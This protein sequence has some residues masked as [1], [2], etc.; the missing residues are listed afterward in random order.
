MRL[1]H[2]FEPTP[3]MRLFAYQRAK[4]GDEATIAAVAAKSSVTRETAS[5]WQNVKGYPEWLEGQVAAHRAPI[6][7]RLDQ[8]ANERLDDFRF[9]EAMAKRV[10]FIAKDG[11]G[12]PGDVPGIRMTPDELLELVKRVRQDAHIK[13]A[14]SSTT[15]A[16]PDGQV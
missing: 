5:R 12:Q 10:A 8:V 15:E 2:E 14:G 13:A 1:D 16:K 4:L 11:A 6:L 9:W 3:A 7:E